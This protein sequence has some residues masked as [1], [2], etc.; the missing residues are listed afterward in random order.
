MSRLIVYPGVLRLPSSLRGIVYRVP[1]EH[2]GKKSDVE[3]RETLGS[4]GHDHQLVYRALEC[5]QRMVRECQGE[6]AD[7]HR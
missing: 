3:L 6:R 1:E 7:G 2:F 5:A 4:C